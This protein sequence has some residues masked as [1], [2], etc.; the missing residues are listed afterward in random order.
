MLDRRERIRLSIRLE[1]G[2]IVYSRIILSGLFVT[3]FVADTTA[4][5]RFRWRPGAILEGLADTVQ[6]VAR[7]IGDRDSPDPPDADSENGVIGIQAHR[8]DLQHADPGHH[9]TPRHQSPQQDT[10]AAS[11]E[12]VIQMVHRGLGES[13]IVRYI[14]D[15]GV[16]QHLSV[17]DLF[18]LHEDG[19]SEPIINAM[20]TARV[21]DVESDPHPVLPITKR[22]PH[23]PDLR[24][25][26]PSR[27]AVNVEQFGPSIL[28]RP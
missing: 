9:A 28:S 19:V 26:N 20:Q 1:L 13:T 7:D 18:R 17:S 27:A 3:L 2:S 6:V 25:S 10:R 11:I 21:Y 12:D 4:Q 15:N 16:K 14:N 5:N 23:R 22:P 8:D 24:F